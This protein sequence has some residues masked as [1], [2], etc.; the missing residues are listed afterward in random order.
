[1]LA[2]FIKSINETLDN[3]SLTQGN[4]FIREEYHFKGVKL[5]ISRTSLR[6]FLV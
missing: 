2:S 6:Y 3:P 5:C 4:F 1:M